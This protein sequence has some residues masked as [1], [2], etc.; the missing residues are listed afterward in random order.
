L[1]RQN[2]KYDYA[3]IDCPPSLGVL[4]LMAL[5]AA[6]SV[7]IPL[8]CQQ[9]ATFGLNDFLETMDLIRNETNPELELLGVLLTMYDVRTKMSRDI[10][11]EVREAVGDKV[12][13]IVIK[14]T[15]K[16]T[17]IA[18]RGPIQAY[19]PRHDTAKA[20][21]ELAREVINHVEAVT[22]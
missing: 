12:F 20:Y 15:T 4:T 8:Q 17:E 2:I 11:R 6:N 9:F 19:E 21:N 22:A 10:A 7:L 3:I 16:L 13:D 14:L 1:E 5:T 18:T